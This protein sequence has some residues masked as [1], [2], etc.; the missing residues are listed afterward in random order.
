M[1]LNRI[2][3]LPVSLSCFSRC[4]HRAACIGAT[5]RPEAG[6]GPNYETRLSG[7]EDSMRDLNGRL[8]QLEFSIRRLDQSM[9][10]LQ[11]DIDARMTKLESA[12]PAAGGRAATTR[13][14]A[15]F[16]RC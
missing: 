3:P 5:R 9:Q 10:R 11:G 7:L 4:Y 14:A 16:R 2:L 1:T 13:A 6:T 12:P 8:E 15:S